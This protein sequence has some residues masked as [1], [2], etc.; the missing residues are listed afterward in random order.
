MTY[1]DINND[2]KV[3]AEDLKLLREIIATLKNS[4][5]L[6][7]QLPPEEKAL[8][9]VDGDGEINYDDVTALCDKVLKNP[10]TERETASLLNE[11]F[12]ALRARASK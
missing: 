3:D 12:A 5:G 8:L 7:D 6:I 4:P 1:G 11:K 10:T 2:G 9:D